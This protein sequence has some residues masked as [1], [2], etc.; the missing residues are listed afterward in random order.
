[1]N[2]FEKKPETK[3]VIAGCRRKLNIFL[4]NFLAITFLT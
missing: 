2:K 4:L 3:L 1:M